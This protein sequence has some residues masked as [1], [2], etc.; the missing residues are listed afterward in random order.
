[1]SIV[2]DSRRRINECMCDCMRLRSQESGVWT[3]TMEDYLTQ[4]TVTV[5]NR[6][7]SKIENTHC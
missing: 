4:L 1:M 2:S 6:D 5:L 3:V 7:N